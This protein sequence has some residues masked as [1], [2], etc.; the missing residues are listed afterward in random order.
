MYI[1]LNNNQIE[2]YPY[3]INQL[4][5]DNAGTS[6]P[7]VIPETLLSEFNVYK[8]KATL[9]PENH[10]AKNISED[11]PVNTNGEWIQTWKIEDKPLDEVEK[12]KESFRAFAYQEE[13]DPLFFKWQRDEATKQEWLDKV[14]EIKQRWS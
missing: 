9:P 13:S 4:K 7:D 12:I 11:T 8:V 1:K 5:Q 2:Q 6:F 14:A 3:S 10:F